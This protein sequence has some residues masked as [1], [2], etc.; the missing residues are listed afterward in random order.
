MNRG[1]PNEN[2]GEQDVE[3]LVDAQGAD[4]QKVY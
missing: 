3:A 4:L 2:I 1:A